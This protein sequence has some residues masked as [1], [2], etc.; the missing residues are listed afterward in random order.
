M[1]ISAA[2]PKVSKTHI[3]MLKKAGAFGDLPE[4][5]EKAACQLIE[6]DKPLLRERQ[7]ERQSSIS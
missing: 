1:G 6:S 2:C 4:S 5:V 3:D 7:H